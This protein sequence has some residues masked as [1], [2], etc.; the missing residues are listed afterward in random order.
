LPNLC[1]NEPAKYDW[2]PKKVPPG[3]VLV[4]GQFLTPASHPLPFALSLLEAQAVDLLGTIVPNPDLCALNRHAQGIT[5]THRSTRTS[6]GS[7]P[8]RIS[9]GA[10][11][12]STGPPRER[13]VSRELLRLLL[14]SEGEEDDDF[15]IKI[16]H[17][18]GIVE[19]I[20]EACWEGRGNF[21]A[22]LA[23]SQTGKGEILRNHH[24]V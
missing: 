23:G 20:V 6:G 22:G 5:G 12:S 18:S 11:W 7:S 19:T 1:R 3:T 14:K 9:L 16:R 8:R 10:L 15:V 13:E 21:P 2:G 24:C 4:F 17:F